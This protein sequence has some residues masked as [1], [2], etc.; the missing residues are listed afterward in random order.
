MRIVAIITVTLLSL[1]VLGYTGARLGGAKPMKSIAR[2]VI[3]G[4]IAMAI[5]MLVGKLF[6]AA[7][8]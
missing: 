8:S 7:V 4:A 2:V 1:V 5:T 6:G 3:G